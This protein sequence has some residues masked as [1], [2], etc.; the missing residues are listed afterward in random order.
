MKTVCLTSEFKTSNSLL[1]ILCGLNSSGTKFR[2]TLFIIGGPRVGQTFRQEQEE[3]K[4][5]QVFLE[6]EE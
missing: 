1:G 4:L 3:V 5:A 6:Q 2:R